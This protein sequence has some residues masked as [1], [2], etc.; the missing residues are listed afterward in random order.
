MLLFRELIRRHDMELKPVSSDVV[1]DGTRI[2]FAYEA[3]QRP[4]TAALQ[5][6][7]SQRLKRRVDLR[8]VGP[9]E[10][11]RLCGGGGLC[12]PVKCCNRFPSHEAPITLRMAK[13][14]ELPM[15]PGRI[16]GLSGVRASDLQVVSRPGAGG[17]QEGVHP[18]WK[19]GSTELRGGARCLPG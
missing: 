5:A 14:Q 6:D 18:T 19:W 9:R 1:F 16:T 10:A 15:N 13:D 17:G 12:G 7:L 3:E 4:D 8:M 2:T 11:A